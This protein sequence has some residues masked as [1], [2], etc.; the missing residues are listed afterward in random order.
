MSV[1]TCWAFATILAFQA[2]TA[3]LTRRDLS[4]PAS[5]G[6]TYT[7]GSNTWTIECG[8]DR[9]L[10]DMPAP[11]GLHAETLEACIDQCTGREGCILVD[12]VPSAKAC[13]VKSSVGYTIAKDT[14]VGAL[15][16]TPSTGSNLVASAPS[17][18]STYSASTSSGLIGASSGKRGL[19]YN[20]AALTKLFGGSGSK[21][22]WAYDWAQTAGPDLNSGLVYIPM[23]WNNAADRVASWMANANAA[24]AAGAD[25]LLGPNEPDLGSQ[26]NMAVS[27]VVSLWKSSMQPFAGKV[28][29]GAPA[30][31][32][33]GAPMGLTY[34]KNF[35]AAC[36][37]CTIDFCPI[38][39]YDSATNIAYFKNYVADAYAACGN[40][41]IWITEFGASGSESEVATFLNTVLP[42]L[43]SNSQVERYAYFMAA[44]STDG[45]YLVNAAGTGLSS[46]GQ[47]Y[48]SA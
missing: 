38:H 13:Y 35:I 29:L 10:G 28:K 24:I 3:P 41:P 17:P 30:V 42:W 48:N 46:I 16:V 4:C 1:L 22:T 47:I 8:I 27:A 26:A 7:S 37:G 20:N 19:C 14:V 6:T 39:W 18:S 36:D 23:L 21:I 25:A 2:A 40:R 31:T 43:D 11:N 5:N 12:Y 33:G 9:Y 34:L 45:T 15:L 32:N 44:A